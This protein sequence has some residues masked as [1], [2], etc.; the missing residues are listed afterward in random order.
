V[1]YQSRSLLSRY[2]MAVAVVAFA[3]G[4]RLALDPALGRGVP[5]IFF[6]PAVLYAA[7][8]GG[9]GAG[10]FAVALSAALSIYLFLGPRF[11]FEVSPFDQVSLA[12]FVAAS[13]AMVLMVERLHQAQA[14]AE[15]SRDEVARQHARFQSLVTSIPGVVWEAWGQPDAA[16]QR[17]DY[18]SPYV[19]T[20]LGYTVE[21]WLATPNFW[22]TIVHPDDREK[23]AAAAAAT[24]AEGGTGLNEFR[25]IAQDGRVLWVQALA[26]VILDRDGKP[27]GMRG[28]TLDVSARREAE[29][30]LRL[31]GEVSEGFGEVGLQ[32]RE[33]AARIARRTTEVV[34]DSCTIR[35]TLDQK[36]VLLGSYHRDP[37]AR[38]LLD[39]V[40]GNH[41]FARALY[42]SVIEARRTIVLPRVDLTPAR[43][44][45]PPAVRPLLDRHAARHAVLS[46]LVSRGRVFGAMGV[47]REEDRP[48]TPEDI[49]LVEAVAARAALALENAMLYE[50]AESALA[51][52]ERESR[53]KDEF[54]AT[55]S[56]ELRTPLNAILGWA[57]ML[58]G[59]RLDPPTV[60]RATET[61]ARNAMAQAQLVS[62][63]LDMQRVVS[64]KMRLDVQELDLADLIEKAVDTIRPSAEAKGIRIQ[65]L[66]DPAAGGNRGDPA[67]LQQVAWNLLANA[68]KFTP[69]GGRVSVQLQ[70]AGSH[71][72]MVVADNG[73]GIPADFLPYVFDRFRQ[74]DSSATRQHGGLGLGLSIVRALV[75]L[76]GGTVQAANGRDGGAVFTVRL[77]RNPA[78]ASS[79]AAA[80]DARAE[81]PV[82][83]DSAPSL[84]GLTVL[85]VEDERDSRELVAA[86]LTRCG[87]RVEAVAS[88]E[89]ALARL[90]GGGVDVIVCDIHMP[91]TDGLTLMRRIRQ[92]EREKGGRIPA[93]ALTASVG[94]ADRIQAL[95]A[96]F[97]VHLG[98][99]VQPAELALAVAGLMMAAAPGSA[100]PATDGA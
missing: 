67:R 48:F 58:N 62:D 29:E 66:L 14:R 92:R 42:G 60:S 54:L 13:A 59:G 2:A 37:E 74:A 33:L 11:T 84:D 65:V 72:E 90:D 5:F 56:H 39:A 76:H 77:P 15:H 1:G 61:I 82:F 89:E 24:F 79:S 70:G 16:A 91:G 40:A 25:W 10:A 69:R 49:R 53:L 63:I 44:A 22:L 97:Q 64:G 78:V 57:H 81:T 3:A 96:G 38:A 86:V 94:A 4:L 88:A 6:F 18:V 85:V 23:A 19:R 68:V 73:P 80:P 27:A 20:M 83:L 26:T 8:Y 46:P 9:G 36:L 47:W 52:A 43:G 7:W 30:R 93:A 75:E 55:L 32:P 95:A 12:V 71:A 51:D 28:V 35:V 100:A 34:G 87:A 17:I 45:L 31:V 99:P 50:R 98:K 21:Q 41:A